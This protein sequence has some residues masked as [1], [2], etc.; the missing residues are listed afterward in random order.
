MLR[1]RSRIVCAA[2]AALAMASIAR[3]DDTELFV[4]GSVPPNLLIILD[5]SNSM[6][7]FN[8]D[9]ATVGD[10]FEGIGAQGGSRLYIAKDVLND[11][12]TKYGDKVNFGLASYDQ[13]AD[14]S[15]VTIKAATNG[16][17][18]AWYY[19]ESWSKIPFGGW[20]AYTMS[21]RYYFWPQYFDLRV[22]QGGLGGPA[23]AADPAG[24]DPAPSSRTPP[25]SRCAGPCAPT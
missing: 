7:W 24:Y 1:L 11:V 23:D 8:K 21:G 5:S 18:R 19:S 25:P 15:N 10:E 13:G 2:L 9:G 4:K 22:P 20:L 14:P 12:V 6:S 17:P 16:A 3:A